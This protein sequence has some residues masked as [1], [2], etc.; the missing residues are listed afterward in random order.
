MYFFYIESDLSVCVFYISTKQEVK[1]TGKGETE[2]EMI[3]IVWGS[4]KPLLT[5]GVFSLSV[6]K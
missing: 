2:S 1:D 6:W 3:D 4:L 5:A